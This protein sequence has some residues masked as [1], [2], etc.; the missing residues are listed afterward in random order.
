MQ[1]QAFYFNSLFGVDYLSGSNSPK[2]SNLTTNRGNQGCQLRRGY[3]LASNL[4]LAVIISIGQT[5]E[6]IGQETEKLTVMTWNLEW[7]FDDQDGDNYSKLAKEKTA[8][9]RADWDWHRDAVAKSIAESKPTILALQEVENRRVLWYLNRAIARDFDLK[10]EELCNES[11]DHFT[12]QDVGM[13]FRTP[14]VIRSIRQFYQTPQQRLDKSYFGV[15]KHLMA[16]FD[17]P[18]GEGTEQVVV[19][20][21]HLRSKAEGAELRMRQARLIRS[22]V[23]TLIE[24]GTN[25]IV[26][27]DM[28]TEERGNKTSLE[29]ELGILCGLNTP[30]TSDDLYDLNLKLNPKE[31]RTHLLPDR[32]FD[33]ILVSKSLLDDAPGRPDLVFDSIRV[34]PNLAI[35]GSLDTPEQHWESYW[36]R[37]QNE[38][39]LSD[40][41]PVEASFVVR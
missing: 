33:R 11:E 31:R 37:P 24:S 39:D 35:Q 36:D 5:R 18:V 19:L 7:F 4:L 40:H 34:L 12:E 32:Q 16:T 27:G 28:N 8:P 22:W 25:V 9:S 30:S 2:E 13:I 6:T 21:V 17:F 3:V 38:R 26:I 1:V 29:N 14:A 15:S 20:N 10:Y 23:S 41:F